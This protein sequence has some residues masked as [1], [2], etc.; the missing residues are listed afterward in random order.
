MPASSLVVWFLR[1]LALLALLVLAV[2][3]LLAASFAALFYSLLALLVQQ[4][5]YVRTDTNC[6]VTNA[7]VS[8]VLKIRMYQTPFL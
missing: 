5:V 2:P 7:R 4:P 1:H 6:N 8:V 3:A